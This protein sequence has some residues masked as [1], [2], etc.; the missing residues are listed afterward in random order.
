MFDVFP[1]R[2]VDDA[3]DAA[4]NRLDAEESD[5][6]RFLGIEAVP[7]RIRGIVDDPSR[8]NVEQLLWLVLLT[9]LVGFGYAYG[10][11]TWDGDTA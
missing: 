5:F 10:I 6:L 4:R 3:P 1:R 8:E 9:A 2:V 11:L 7:R